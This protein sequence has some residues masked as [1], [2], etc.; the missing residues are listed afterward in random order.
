V[1]DAP[2]G[3]FK[4]ALGKPLID[5][6]LMPEAGEEP[7][8][9]TI[10]R[11][12][13]GQSYMYFSSRTLK[14]VKL[15]ASMIKLAGPLQDVAFLDAQ[16]KPVPVAAS[17]KQPVLPEGYAEAP[18]AFKRAGKYYLMYSNGW[19]RTSALVYAMSAKP[20]GPFT[21]AGKVMEH[22]PGNTQHGSVAQFHDKWYVAYHTN[23]LSNGNN[24]RR[25]VCMDELT[26]DKDGKINTITATKQGPA[27][28]PATKP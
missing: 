15:D 19:D 25:S 22:V 11:D 17:G 1:A 23:E 21:Y 28:A 16:G 9:P 27:T 7:I 24:F 18:F 26:F 3:P 5:N 10:L 4:D 6:K 13:D 8:D 12:D 14:V 2:E 20:E